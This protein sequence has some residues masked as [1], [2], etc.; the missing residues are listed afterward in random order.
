MKCIEKIHARCVVGRR[1]K[2]LSGHVAN[3][4]PENASVLDVGCG[5]GQI[6]SMVRLRRPDVNIRGVD[7]LVRG[8][9]AIPVEPFD[10][11]HLPF[12]D[13]SFDSVMFIDVLHH[14]QD[15]NRLLGEAARVAIEA[16]VI[17]DHLRE[18]WLADST[19][20][21]MDRLGNCRH[22]VALPHNY[23]SR[24]RWKEAFRPHGLQLEYW[25]EDLGLY[26][27]P[28]SMLFDRHL[29]FVARLTLAAGT[30]AAQINNSQ[31][32]S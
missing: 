4:L 17:K 15:P 19:L 1:A 26:P 12:E 23:W 31:C 32:S 14:T 25:R 7:V 24:Q 5:D 16:I 11:D 6:A 2:V 28:A 9:T 22:G 10:G 13:N 30:I 21:F 3:L 29:H 8:Q 27:W 20:R 18:G